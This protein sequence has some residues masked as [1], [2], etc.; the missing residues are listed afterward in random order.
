MPSQDL[1]SPSLVPTRTVTR[2]QHILSWVSA[3]STNREKELHPE[4]TI[5]LSQQI[6]KGVGA[7]IGPWILSIVDKSNRTESR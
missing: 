4:A 1:P 2:L 3:E 5:G 6:L 7:Y